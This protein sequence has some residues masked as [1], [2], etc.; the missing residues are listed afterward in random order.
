MKLETTMRTHK[1]ACGRRGLA[2]GQA[3]MLVALLAVMAASLA[4][5]SITSGRL[6]DRRSLSLWALNVAQ[7]GL[8]EAR[9][10]FAYNEDFLAN[11]ASKTYTFNRTEAGTNALLQCQ[12]VITRNDKAS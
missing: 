7:M 3:I 4:G 10:D 8:E 11:G 6:A 5:L 9:A 2:L 12:F 1:K